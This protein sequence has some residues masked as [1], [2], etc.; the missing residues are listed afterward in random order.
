VTLRRTL[1]SVELE[2]KPIRNFGDQ[3]MQGAFKMTEL[4]AFMG[5]QLLKTP[6]LLLHFTENQSIKT[7]SSLSLPRLAPHSSF[8]VASSS[9][10]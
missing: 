2:A 9:L 3:M 7:L 6:P 1:L 8:L 10:D 4:C 5:Q